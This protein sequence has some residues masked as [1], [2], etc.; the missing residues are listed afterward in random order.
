MKKRKKV[1]M[2]K[3]TGADKTLCFNEKG[4]V[5]WDYTDSPGPTVV[6][7][8]V[9]DQLVAASNYNAVTRLP[10][11]SYPEETKPNGGGYSLQIY[12]SNDGSYKSG[13]L[14]IGCKRVPRAL[15]LRVHKASQLIRQ[16]KN[17]KKV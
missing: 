10:E 3:F 17:P 13:D 9:L 14:Q 12:T 6:K 5:C 8:S 16:R 11:P 4:D 2:L 15:L 7:A 1:K